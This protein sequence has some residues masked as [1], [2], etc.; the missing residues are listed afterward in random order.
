VTVRSPRRTSLRVSALNSSVYFLGTRM[1]FPSGACQRIGGRSTPQERPAAPPRAARTNSS[2]R[3]PENANLLKLPYSPIA[4]RT[5]R[6]KPPAPQPRLAPDA[7]SA[8]PQSPGAL[9]SERIRDSSPSNLPRTRRAL[10]NAAIPPPVIQRGA[11]RK[12][13]TRNRTSARPP[14]RDA[15]IRRSVIRQAH[16]RT[17][18]ERPT[19]R[20]RPLRNAAIP[21]RVIQR[22]MRKPP[23][24]HPTSLPTRAP[25]RRNSPGALY[26]ERICKPPLSYLRNLPRTRGPLRNV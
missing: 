9:Y 14:L 22:R 3:P 26:S 20:P 2:G 15:A 6:G 23:R 10:R 4:N 18:A 1:K 24:R 25:Q 8:M 21:P 19:S 13:P 7:R 17:A 5:A 12:P 16:L 11:I